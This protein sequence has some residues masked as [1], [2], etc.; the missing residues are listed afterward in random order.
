MSLKRTS[1]IGYK[2][3]TGQDINGYLALRLFCF[4]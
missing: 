2:L 1:P 4:A 3:S